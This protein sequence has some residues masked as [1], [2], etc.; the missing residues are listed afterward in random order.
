M[1]ATY[2]NLLDTAPDTYSRSRLL[3]AARKESGAWLHV[4]PMSALGLR[5]DDEVIQVAMGL[6]LGATLC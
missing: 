5:M 2:K 1:L 6:R 3:A 4:S